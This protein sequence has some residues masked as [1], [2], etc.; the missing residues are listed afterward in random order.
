MIDQQTRKY[1]LG[2]FAVQVYFENSAITFPTTVSWNVF[3]VP[4]LCCFSYK[5]VTVVAWWGEPGEIESYSSSSSSDA[6]RSA[7]ASRRCD[8]S[9]ERSVLR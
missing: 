5:Y 1:I 8:C 7:E 6:K 2:Y 4:E 3:V 9:P